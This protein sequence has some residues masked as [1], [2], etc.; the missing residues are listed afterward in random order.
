MDGLIAQVAYYH[1]WT[2]CAT[3]VGSRYRLMLPAVTLTLVKSVPPCHR[4]YTVAGRH[5]VK[6][7]VRV[8]AGVPILLAI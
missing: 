6:V 3:S 1:V 7:H 8:K 4:I 5:V 2:A